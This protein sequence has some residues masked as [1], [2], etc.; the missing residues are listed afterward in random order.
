MDSSL[1]VQTLLSYRNTW[2][3]WPLLGLFLSLLVWLI[4]SSRVRAHAKSVGARLAFFVMPFLPRAMLIVG[5]NIYYDDEFEVVKGENGYHIKTR[6]GEHYVSRVDPDENVQVKSALN[7]RGPEG[8]DSPF[9]LAWR[10]IVSASIMVY[11]V[12]LGLLSAWMDPRMQALEWFAV[13]GVPVPDNVTLAIVSQRSEAIVY[14]GLLAAAVLAWWFANLVRFTVRGIKV[15]KF[16]ELSIA[17]STIEVMPAVEP[18]SPSSVFRFLGSLV[19]GGVRLELT[20]SARK[21]LE[22]LAARMKTDAATVVQLLNK[23]ALADIWRKEI[24]DQIRHYLDVKR[25]AEAECLLKSRGIA[26]RIVASIAKIAVLALIGGLFVGL[27]GGYALGAFY[28]KPSIHKVNST[29]A[30]ST[31]PPAASGPAPPPG[32]ASATATITPAQPPPP[33]IAGG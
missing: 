1:L 16:I 6:F 20:E 22:D 14:A 26:P 18:D 31:T 24:G 27:M 15:M 21:L 9:S 25:A 8:V 7:A 17:S 28:G 4:L 11:F 13:F 2:Y 5:R 30:E 33:P 3:Q 10:W 23:A 32:N 29:A 12:T 19:R